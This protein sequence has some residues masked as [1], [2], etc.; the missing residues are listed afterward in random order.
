M[1]RLTHSKVL[2]VFSFVIALFTVSCNSRFFGKI[3]PHKPASGEISSHSSR[4]YRE[5]RQVRKAKEIQ[6][7]RQRSNKKAYGKSIERSRKR[8]YE[9]QTPEVKA[10][11]KQNQADLS[12]R[13][14]AKSKKQKSASRKSGK[15]YK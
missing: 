7:K 13:E 11:M 5:Q 6:A 10:R 4:G 12:A 2:V 9:I 15:K 14:K 8:T 1:N 3:L